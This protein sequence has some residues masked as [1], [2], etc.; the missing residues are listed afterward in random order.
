M[1][2]RRLAFV[3]GIALAAGFM[4]TA[5][6]ARA[7]TSNWQS[8]CTPYAN[9]YWFTSAIKRSQAQSYAAVGVGEGYH[10]GGGCWN[11]NN[12]DDARNEPQENNTSTHGEGPDCSGV[13]YKT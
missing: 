7:G 5:G 11:D 10:W 3:F 9:Q 4:M 2:T 8:N 6:A 12:T 1:R 13:V